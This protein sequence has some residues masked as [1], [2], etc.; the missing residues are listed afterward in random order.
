VV[1]PAD[2]AWH[3]SRREI[4][5]ER[6]QTHAAGFKSKK[7]ADK[8]VAGRKEKGDCDMK[9]LQAPNDEHGF[10]GSVESLKTTY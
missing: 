10:V 1:V 9:V 6:K 8:N 7:D 3:E 2:A 4:P 5:T